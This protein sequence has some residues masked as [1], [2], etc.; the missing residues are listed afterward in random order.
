MYKSGDL[1]RYRHDRI[2]E[3][4]GR[5]DN[6]VKV[7]G[8]RIE[9]RE[10][11]ATLA[12]H[13]GVQ[14]CAV[15]AREDE[16]GNRQLVGYVSPAKNQ[17]LVPE[18]LRTFLEQRLPAYMVPA[19][20][21]LL[22][23]LPLTPNG[24]VNRKALPAPSYERIAV[25]TTTVAPRTGTEKALA[26][27]W[28]DLLKVDSIG[29]NDNFFDL[30]GHSLLAFKA[31]SRIR[32][33]FS[34]DL[35]VQDLFEN[36]TI[37]GIAKLLPDA[38]DATGEVQRIE[39]RKG[40]GPFPLS[41][42]QQQL[43]FLNQLAPGS[44]VYNIVDLIHLGETY[45]PEALRKAVREL[46][47]RH[48][49][50][51]T[52][53]SY[54]DGQPMQVVSPSAEVQLSELDLSSLP[55]TDRER[56]WSRIVHEQSRRPFDLSQAPL[57]RVTIIHKSA[58]QHD[59]L[60][61]IHHIIA[62]EWGMGL[63]HREIAQ[64]YD[65]FSRGQFSSLAELPIQYA[66]FACWQRNRLQGEVLEKQLAYWKNEL[67]GAPTVLELASD[68]PRPAIQSFRGATQFFH[69]PLN[70]SESMKSLGRQEQATLFMTLLASFM[71]LLYRYT[72]QDDVLV[73][74]PVSLRT[75]GE[76][77][78]LIGYFL[79]TVILRAQF[80]NGMSFRSLLQQ[81]RERALG[82]YAHADL[83]FNHLIAELSPA[84]DL[85]RS[86]L[87][88][89]MFVLHDPDGISE[90]S[91]ISG[92]DQL[93][94]GT[95]KFDLTLSIID[96][97]NGL[98]ASIEYSTDLFTPQ[99]IQR[100]GKHFGTLLEAIGSNPD[101][102][103]SKLAILA[104]ADRRQVLYDW[105]DTKAD[106]PSDKCVHE[107]F[108]E[109]VAR[110]PDATAVV[111]EDRSLSYAELNRRANQLAHHLR[112]LGVGPDVLVAICV[113][114]GLEMI[115]SL[116]AVL[117]AGGAYVPLDPAYPIERLRFMLQDSAP[118]ALL[119]QGNL[120]ELFKGIGDT[121]PVIDVTAEASEWRNEPET[122]PVPKDFGLTPNQLA[123][124]IY[125]S[126][127]TGQPKGVMVCHRNLV[128]ST[129][130]RKLVYGS[131]GRFL[132]LSP[133]SFDSSVAGIFGVLTTAGELFIA[134]INVIRDP[135]RLYSEIQRLGIES[136]LCVPSLYRQILEYSTNDNSSSQRHLSR[137]IVA[138]ERCPVELVIKS[139]Q[140]EPQVVL[141][142]EYGPTE[143]TV[144]ATVY[145]CVGQSPKESIPIGRPISNTR[146]YI[147]DAH[148]EP[149]PVG[150]AGELYIG[151]A[152]VARGYLNRPELT[153]AKFLPDPFTDEPGARMYRT[154]DLGRWLADGNIEFL[155]RNDF[156]V[157]IRGFRIEL[158]EI[159][160]RLAED[161]AVREAAVIA[162]EDTPGDKRLVAYY[163]TSLISDFG[164]GSLSVEQ[165]RSH[166]SIDLPV[167]MIPAAYVHL[168]S[169]PLT[170]N[171]K[172]DR[173][174]LPAPEA[175]AYSTY[176]YEPP[177]GEMEME[178]AAI[179]TDVLKL[180][181]VGRQDNFFKLG[182][183]SLAAVQVVTRLRQALSVEL[184]IRDLFAHPVLH[185]FAEHITDLRLA[186]FS[187]EDIARALKLM[188]S[189]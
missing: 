103:V 116:L 108:E 4:L 15:L 113:D 76:T 6:Q 83:P 45:N 147:L 91:R 117:K 60:V 106:Y 130:A 150:V 92:R 134:S 174:A 25:T 44:P 28:A 67:A 31:V 184:T 74:T 171:G 140:N 55:E 183:H 2:L 156:Q 42:G 139:T 16:P 51:R 102:N 34:V 12:S 14:S 177:Q 135:S 65:D 176:S 181:R 111:F 125:T 180:E 120:E 99:T 124:V 160:A 49:T 46:V 27:I 78:N 98:D 166:L 84:R 70:V 72:G 73:G 157:K 62:D 101:E 172:L 41:A 47:R 57:L 58:T 107:L 9:P 121:L 146:I 32:D 122:N 161:P 88:Q 162:R 136:V 175:D 94:T 90:V 52:A 63:I 131:F 169:L 109:Q 189:A 182:G 30:G 18:E 163:T 85:S 128:S 168:E 112:G 97:K 159:E 53:F 71:A 39:R 153:A 24:K 5:A 66:D 68:K 11:E 89:V 142:N 115:V 37:A 110:T 86:P 36:P 87:F 56:E 167:Y 81:V 50:L 13:P 152:G 187:P 3:Y 64:L 10:I 138:G 69:V 19:H 133:I 75:L 93:E 105:N 17:S 118:V 164:E 178:L 22:G 127:S 8:Y 77:E 155:G 82:A 54:I 114:R 29:V 79:N 173:K 48:E 26:A 1:A 35:P 61:V 96:M 148:G 21:V 95:S 129:F 158:G 188:Q 144:W 165:L 185:L 145:R 80:K 40:D 126:G 119:T 100:I 132:L 179:W 123:Y 43:W 7:R 20:F 151:G 154:G 141:F 170:P 186:Q 38:D 137:A 33:A 104:N 59:L 143:S 149:V 23:S